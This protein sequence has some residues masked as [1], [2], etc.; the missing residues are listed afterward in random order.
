MD[1]DARNG[2]GTGGK[3]SAS[4]EDEE[5][6]A[7]VTK[8]LG[9]PMPDE[10]LMRTVKSMNNKLTALGYCV[11]DPTPLQVLAIEVWSLH[12]GLIHAI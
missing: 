4:E 1:E 10:R 2:L 11:D 3:D 6:E 8:L 9:K 12:A 7:P 5:S